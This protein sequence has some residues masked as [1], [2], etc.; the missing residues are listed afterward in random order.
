VF[1]ENSKLPMPYGALRSEINSLEEKK[2]F[3]LSEHNL[4]VMN[5][6]APKP[7]KL[8]I[9]ARLEQSGQAGPDKPGDLTGE[10]LID[11]GS[12]TTVIIN[13]LIK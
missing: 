8:R 7:Q 3:F 1:D 6:A 12:E 2:E 10:S 11:I 5:P 13:K 9:K 4:T